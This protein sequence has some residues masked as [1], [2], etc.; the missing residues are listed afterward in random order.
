MQK[1]EQNGNIFHDS[2]FSYSEFK[3]VYKMFYIG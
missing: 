3:I 2:S 1:N